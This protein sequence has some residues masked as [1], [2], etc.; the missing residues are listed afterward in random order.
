MCG[1]AAELADAALDE[2]VR[3]DAAPGA[4]EGDILAAMQGAI[5]RGGGDYPANESSS[6]RAR[7]AAVPLLHRAP[8]TSTPQDQ[9]HAGIRRRVPPLPCLPD[10]HRSAS[11][12]ADRRA[13]AHVRRGARGACWPAR[14]R[15]S[16]APRWPRCSTPMRGSIDAH[17][18]SEHRL[19]RLRL[20]ARRHLRPQLDGLADVL[21]R[22]PAA[23]RSPAWCSSCT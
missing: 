7:R 21:C 5:F 2:A 14:P 22:Q 9:L 16:P 11:A 19:E 6:A 23:A 13:S 18:M 17:G 12:R 3:A 4:F 20:R 8:R 1:S 15:S 10:A